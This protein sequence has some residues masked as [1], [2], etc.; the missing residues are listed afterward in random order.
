[1]LKKYF[2]IIETPYLQAKTRVAPR[3]AKSK[4]ASAPSPVFAPVITITYHNTSL[5]TI[6]IVDILKKMNLIGVVVVACIEGK[7]FCQACLRQ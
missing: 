1:M 3:F 6:L 7:L 4:A 2:E 5:E